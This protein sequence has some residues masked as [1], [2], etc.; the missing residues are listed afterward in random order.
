MN[1]ELLSEKYNAVFDA[2]GNIKVC[3]REKCK[4]L[5]FALQ[6]A[7]GVLTGDLDSGRLNIPLTKETYLKYITD[8]SLTSC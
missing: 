4:E 1:R 6:N 2:D 7:T 5:M 8:C 3:G